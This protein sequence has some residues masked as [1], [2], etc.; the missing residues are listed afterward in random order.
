MATYAF[1]SM[2]YGPDPESPDN[3]WTKLYEHGL[4]PLETAS[5]SG[6]DYPDVKLL[7]ADRSLFGLSFKVN[8]CKNIERSAFV[9][10]VLTTQEV[11]NGGVRVSNPNVLWEVGYAEALGKPIVMLVDDKDDPRKLPLLTNE[12]VLFQYSHEMVKACK[13]KDAA[14]ALGVIAKNM[15][16]HCKVAIANA[17]GGPKSRTWVNAIAYSSRDEVPL[18]AM[19]GRARRTVEVLSTNV[20]Y[21]LS[22]AFYTGPTATHPFA[23]ALR[24]G[25]RVSIVTMDPECLI[26][27]YRAKQ[28]YRGADV[29]G[30]RKELR[31]GI[32]L[33]YE[34]YKNERNFSVHL[35]NDLPL[36]ITVRVDETILTSVVTRGAQARRRIQM[37][38]DL[39]Y[40]PVSESFVTHFQTMYDS[41]EDLRN[42]RWATSPPDSDL[43]QRL[44]DPFGAAD[45]VNPTG[46]PRGRADSLSQWP[47]ASSSRVTGNEPETV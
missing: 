1:V 40:P 28:L 16:E 26:A 15:R 10:A 31:D 44:E 42:V 22:R 4:R 8:V 37:Q 20:D 29:P 39:A 18:G 32:R 38:F 14:G 34:L 46:K 17:Y 43:L 6:S 11:G 7:R 24:N 35:Y 47:L 21:Y 33:L 23:A 13:A 12:Y 25:A 5:E 30:Y 2:P 9:I 45:V 27:E 36:Q 3:E 19:I 41:S